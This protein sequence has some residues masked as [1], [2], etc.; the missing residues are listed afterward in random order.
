M[1]KLYIYFIWS[2]ACMINKDV[3]C[4]WPVFNLWPHW[5]TKNQQKDT[6]ILRQT[7]V[8]QWK[9]KLT[10]TWGSDSWRS[11]IMSGGLCSN[12]LYVSMI[13]PASSALQASIR[14]RSASRQTR[15]RCFSGTWGSFMSTC[16]R[17]YV[18]LAFVHLNDLARLF[19]SPG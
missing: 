15:V 17:R 19:R 2:I 1:Q 8:K 13:L 6:I 9:T 5:G 7:K 18:T 14:V 10:L 12:I 16:N 3:L 11:I 4:T